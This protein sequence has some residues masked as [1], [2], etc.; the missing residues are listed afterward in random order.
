[1]SAAGAPVPAAPAPMPTAYSSPMPTTSSSAPIVTFGVSISAAVLFVIAVYLFLRRSAQ[2]NRTDQTKVDDETRFGLVVQSSD[3]ALTPEIRGLINEY[4]PGAWH[5]L[6]PAEETPNV[7]VREGLTMLFLARVRTSQTDVPI[8]IPLTFK[9]VFY[10]EVTCQHKPA[11]SFVSIGVAPKGY[12]EFMLG[13]GATTWSVGYRSDARKFVQGH[14]GT[15]GQP[16]GEPFGG[17]DVIGNTNGS[18]F[19]TKNGRALSNATDDIPVDVALYPSIGATRGVLLNINFGQEPFTFG[20]AEAHNLGYM[21]DRLPSYPARTATPSPASPRSGSVAGRVSARRIS[22]SST[23]SSSARS[24]SQR[25]S[26]ASGMSHLDR[27]LLGSPAAP[28]AAAAIASDPATAA[29]VVVPGSFPDDGLPTDSLDVELPRSVLRWSLSAH[30]SLPPGY[31]VAAYWTPGQRASGAPSDAAA[32]LTRTPSGASR[33]SFAAAA[34]AAR[35]N[36]MSSGSSIYH[37]VVRTGSRASIASVASSVTPSDPP[38]PFEEAMRLAAENRWDEAFDAAAAALATVEDAPHDNSDAGAAAV[39]AASIDVAVD[40][41]NDNAT[42]PTAAIEMTEVVPPPAGPLST[43]DD[44]HSD[45]HE[46]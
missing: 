32:L 31:D 9:N 3:D 7:M 40:P 43:V 19:Y 10:Y 38:P 35:R 46:S 33:R 37:G 16:F 30:Q 26:V 15:A 39:D 36:R 6:P 20:P 41:I 5:F 18:V 24:T 17:G 4:G 23:T 21:T 22:A 12:P 34:V 11:G 8:P 13:P 25:S 45:R 42:E 28:S 44:V 14:S 2:V 29:P 1:M 27:E